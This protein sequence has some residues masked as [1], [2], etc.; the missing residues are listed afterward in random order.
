[1]RLSLRAKSILALAAFAAYLGAA[2]LVLGGERQKLL[3]L[4]L[5]LEQ[6]YEKDSQVA[7]TAYSIHHSLVRLE[8]LLHAASPYPSAVEDVA[9]DLE[10]VQAGLQNLATSYP[11]TVAHA[12]RLSAAIA[13]LRQAY[14]QAAIL[15]LRKALSL[16]ESRTAAIDQELRGIHKN[17]W[18]AY[19]RV[20]EGMTILVTVTLLFGV[21]V[22]GGITSLFVTRLAWD[23]E[24]LE[25]RSHQIV[26]GF[27]GEPL[28]VTRSDEV[29]RLMAAVNRMQSELRR[30]EQQLEIVRQQRFHQEKMAAVGSLAAAVAHEINNPIAAISGIARSIAATGKCGGG[31][32]DDFEGDGPQL[33]L[34]QAERI[35]SISRQVAEFTRPHSAL[36]ELTDL[37]RLVRSVCKFTGYDSR[38]RDVVLDLDLDASL[39]AVTCVADHL[40]QVLMNL[41]INAG[42]AVR[43][44]CDRRPRIVVQTRLLGERFLVR[45]ADNGQGMDGQTLARVFEEGFTTKGAGQ[46]LGLGL[47]LCKALVERDGGTIGIDTSPGSGTTVTV[48]LPIAPAAAAA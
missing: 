28:P 23:I 35:S 45:V 30:H 12:G 8:S 37:N 5:E 48:N 44:A 11:D 19:Y 3:S 2:S 38:L 41:L 10:L 21:L 32:S 25:E 31:T 18:T 40:T 47:F 22:F 6:V 20:H 16:L 26:A 13:A 36:P 4:A 33:I 27:R 46:G 29:G 1:M 7:R 42:D 14:S 34:Q 9:L 17:T 39:P 24:R 15:D 43:S